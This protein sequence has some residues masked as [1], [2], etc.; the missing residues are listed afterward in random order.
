MTR[1]VEGDVLSHS[2]AVLNRCGGNLYTV[3]LEHYGS[4]DIS[5]SD[6]SSNGA[7]LTLCELLVFHQLH[8]RG[9][10]NVAV[11]QLRSNHA[12]GSAVHATQ[13]VGLVRLKLHI[14]VLRNVHTRHLR[15]AERAL[16]LD[17]THVVKV[18]G[19]DT[20]ETGVHLRVS[21][22]TP[23]GHRV[24]GSCSP[25]ITASSDIA[26]TVIQ[27]ASALEFSSRWRI[28]AHLINTGRKTETA[29]VD[30][31]VH[32]QLNVSP[33]LNDFR[34]V[35]GTSLAVDLSTV[36]VIGV[37]TARATDDGG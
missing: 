2:F 4:L 33:W 21:L 31:H 11:R 22:R 29:V 32:R 14:G 25:R 1:F 19:V 8:N 27:T 20:K 10:T 23:F 13:V 6:L 24:L 16:H 5:R 36:R 18:I 34:R 37:I 26:S 3:S 28:N 35:D 17:V 15:C 7:R 30:H 12:E 9:T